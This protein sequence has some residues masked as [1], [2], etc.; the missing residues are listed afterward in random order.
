MQKPA[1]QFP[2]RV[3]RAAH[4]PKL[5]QGEL[6]KR[7]EARLPDGRTMSSQ[8]IWQIEHGEGPAPDA[9]QRAAI[10][11][12]LG[13]KETSIAWPDFGRATGRALAS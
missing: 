2:I 4:E 8:R 10:A 11:A 6:A 5:T 9:D 3:F 1:G 13:V 7:V 12:A